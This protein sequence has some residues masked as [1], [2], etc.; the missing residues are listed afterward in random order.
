MRIPA[1]AA[2]AET[3]EGTKTLRGPNLRGLINAV[4][5]SYLRDQEALDEKSDK[6]QCWQI[7]PPKLAAKNASRKLPT[8]MGAIGRS[9]Q[10]QSAN[11]VACKP[12]TP[13][14]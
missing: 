9:E 12:S 8:A 6:P 14:S 3:V 11:V 13:Y 5:R 2:V 7:W 10:Q 4:L 1:H